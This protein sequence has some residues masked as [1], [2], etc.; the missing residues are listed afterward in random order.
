M[1]RMSQ[2][3]SRSTHITA[4]MSE[5]TYHSTRTGARIPQHAQQARMSGRACRSTHAVARVSRRVY[6]TVR[7]E[8][9]HGHSSVTARSGTAV[10]AV[11]G[12]SR[13]CSNTRPSAA[14]WVAPSLFSAAG[15]LGLDRLSTTVRAGIRGERKQTGT[16]RGSNLRGQAAGPCGAWHGIVSHG[17]ALRSTTS[18]YMTLPYVAPSRAASR[19]STSPLPSPASVAPLARRT[20]RRLPSRADFRVS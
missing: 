14:S 1:A 12:R 18:H 13:F 10:S 9:A 3:A 17:I 19:P 4:R 2:H 11:T 6:H 16:P 5:H 7:S 20:R 8:F 15:C